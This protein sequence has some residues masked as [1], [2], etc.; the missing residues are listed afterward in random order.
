M[1]HTQIVAQ[2]TWFSLKI[3]VVEKG[4]NLQENILK[5]AP[6]LNKKM[7]LGYGMLTGEFCIINREFSDLQCL[8]NTLRTKILVLFRWQFNQSLVRRWDLNLGPLDCKSA[9]HPDCST[10]LPQI[11]IVIVFFSPFFIAFNVHWLSVRPRFFL[12]HIFCLF[13][14]IV[15]ASICQ[16]PTEER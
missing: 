1:V 7:A 8:M 10:T 9:M 11:F 14:R 4:A 5:E 16:R 13:F 6:C 3:L 2:N 12:K 15:G